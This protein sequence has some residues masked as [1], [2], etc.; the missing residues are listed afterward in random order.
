MKSHYKGYILIILSAVIFGCMPIGAKM[1][2][3]GGGNSFSLVLYRSLFALPTLFILMLRKKDISMT[4]TKIEIKKVII[5]VVGGLA[6]TPILLFSSYN[7]ISSGTSTVVH[8]VYPI[9]VLFGCAV[10]FGEKINKIKIICVILCMAGIIFL[11]SPLELG[12]ILGLSLSFI[13]GITYAF[14]IVY[15]DKSG[16]KNMYPFK[17]GFYAAVVSCVVMLIFTLSAGKLVITMTPKGWIAT[18]I[19]ANAITVGAVVL[20]QIGVQ[21]ISSQKAAILS[22]FEPITSIIV[23]VLF[24]DEIFTFKIAIGSFL[25]L[26]SVIILTVFDKEKIDSDCIKIKKIQKYQL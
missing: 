21:T 14:Y 5:L 26:S 11:S 6:L 9:F 15:L 25:I 23:G 7:Y 10:F 19:F 13:S 20:F 2:Y 3:E 4:I 18:I 1:V 22:T 8:F 12:S 16:L 24:M 17:L